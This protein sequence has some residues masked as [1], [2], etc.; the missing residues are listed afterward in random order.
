MFCFERSYIRIMEKRL[1]TTVYSGSL[2]T[3]L[4]GVISLSKQGARPPEPL[5]AA[6][7]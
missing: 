3:G 4:I 1:E 5:Q 6:A 7:G 2:E